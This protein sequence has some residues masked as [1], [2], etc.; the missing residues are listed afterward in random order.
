MNSDYFRYLRKR[1]LIGIL[2][3]RLFLMPVVN[4]FRGNVLD[5]GSGIGEFLEYYPDSVGIDVNKDCV[6][7]CV[8]KGLKCF[9]ADVYRLPFMD[10]SFDGVL[11][12]NILEHLGKPDD[13]FSEIKRVLRNDGRLLIELP[14]KKGF[15][16]DKTHVKFWDKTEMM[17]F[18][19]K[20]GF[21]NITARFFPVPFEFAGNALTHNKLRVFAVNSK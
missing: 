18:L 3:R 17:D 16:Y 13:A 6:E 7:S 12:N 8:S 11:L 2:F 5:I 21:R 1:S 19:A 10:N 14:G 4:Y 15:C 20:W 9:H